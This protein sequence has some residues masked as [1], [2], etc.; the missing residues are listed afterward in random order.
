[1][2]KRQGLKP[3]AMIGRNERML[4]ASMLDRQ[5]VYRSVLRIDLCHESTVLNRP[6]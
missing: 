5:P 3:V 1:M 4:N 2:L 6:L